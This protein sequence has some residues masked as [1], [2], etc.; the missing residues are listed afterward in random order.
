[1]SAPLS[2]PASSSEIPV[3]QEEPEQSWL[4][5]DFHLHASEDPF[6]EL[7]HSAI[8]LLYR[9]HYLGF[10]ALAITLHDHVLQKPE[11]FEVARQLGILLI[12]AAEVRLEGADVVVVNLTEEEAK[13]LRRLRD[14]EALRRRRGD[15]VFIFAPHPFYHLGGSIGHQKLVEHIDLFDAIELCHFHTRLVN[16]NRGAYNI[17]RQFDKPL[18]ATSDAHRLDFFGEHYSLVQAPPDPEAIFNA[19][20]TRACRTVSPPWPVSRFLQYVWW[21]L[22]EHEFRLLQARLAGH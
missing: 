13:D 4:K 6:D 22:A 12:P 19:I 8:D 11:V 17:A 15:S 2:D 20:R 9:A 1:M 21:V 7:E 5:I 16:P 18:L 14:L 10:G 3:V